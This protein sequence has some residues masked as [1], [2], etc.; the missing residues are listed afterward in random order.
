MKRIVLLCPYFGIFPNYFNYFLL[1]CSYNKNF[2]WIIFTDNNCKE[3]S[4]PSNVYIYNMSFSEMKTMV[5]Q[6]FDFKISL[7]TPYK[8]CDYKPAYG[9]I[10]SEYI[11][12]YDFW[13]YCDID[14]IY[15]NLDNFISEYITNYDKLFLSGH[16]TLYKNIECN[17]LT[18]SA[19]LDYLFK[20][21]IINRDTLKNLMTY[22]DVFS[23]PDILIFDE[24]HGYFNI[25]DIY[26]KLN[27]CSYDNFSY[28]ADVAANYYNFYLTKK[29]E[30]YYIVDERKRNV[31]FIWDKGY[32]YGYYKENSIIK[33]DE[34][35]YIHLQKRKMHIADKINQDEITFG[36]VPNKFI[37]NMN[38]INN[39]DF[40]NYNKQDEKIENYQVV[41]EKGQYTRITK[42]IYIELMKRANR[43]LLKNKKEEYYETND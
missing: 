7:D 42:R 24:D 2:N 20:K 12:E 25:H 35:M 21:N 30:D 13:G 1:S 38:I 39:D 3:I 22:K 26:D 16:F 29:I 40:Q 11:K 32:L 14:V 6:K 27:L 19:S 43:A 10:F 37:N 23:T 8:F 33:R 9:Y 41:M 5:Q 31:M 36:I 34:F 28:I 17:N 15:G 4:I 18:F